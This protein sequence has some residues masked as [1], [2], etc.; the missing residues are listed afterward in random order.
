MTVRRRARDCLHSITLSGGATLKV[1]GPVR[2]RLTG[3]FTAS[4]NS[5]ANPTPIPSNLQ[6][7]ASYTGKDGV[8]LSGGA[9]GH[10]VVYAPG[11]GV[12]LSGNAELFGAV[13]GKTVTMTGNP[14]LHYDVRLLGV[15]GALFGL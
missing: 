10:F 13:V 3:T 11:T 1:S 14:A 9:S 5:V 7:E 2:I 8:T 12:T 4:G 6:I 15:W